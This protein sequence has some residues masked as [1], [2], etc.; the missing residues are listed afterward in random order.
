MQ[1]DLIQILNL[2]ENKF[3]IILSQ[4]L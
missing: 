3:K 2:K 4:N 1:I